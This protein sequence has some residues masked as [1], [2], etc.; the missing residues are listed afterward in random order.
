M[1]DFIYNMLSSTIVLVIMITICIVVFYFIN[2]RQ[3]NAKRESYVMLHQSLKPNLKVEFAGGLVGKL[4][5][6]GD[7]YC[8]AELTKGMVITISRYS[9][10]RVIGK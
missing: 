6:V 1:E 4:V 2:R 10:S 5:S 3:V 8:E 7:E 9:I